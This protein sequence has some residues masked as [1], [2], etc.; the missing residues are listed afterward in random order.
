MSKPFQIMMPERALGLVAEAAEESGCKSSTWARQALYAALRASGRDP[1][2][3]PPDGGA[4][5][6]QWALVIGDEVKALHQANDKPADEQGGRW[7]PVV[8]ADSQL[9]DPEIHYRTPPW[10][11]VEASRVV[12]TYPVV[13]KAE[14]I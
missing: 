5:I 14:A 6:Q 2:G 3:I 1:T 4:G 8:Y 10:M 7:L 9:F 11:R 12:R 13:E